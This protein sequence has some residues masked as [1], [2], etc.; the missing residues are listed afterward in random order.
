MASPRWPASMLLASLI[1][2]YWTTSFAWSHSSTDHSALYRIK[3]GMRSGTKENTEKI[4]EIVKSFLSVLKDVVENK[5]LK[6]MMQNLSAFAS[7]APGI[8]TLISA[9]INMALGFT[10][11]NDPLLKELEQGFAEVNRKLDSLSIKM[12]DLSTD[13]E[14]NSF[15]SIYSQ[16]EACILNAWKKFSELEKK[17]GFKNFKS[18][19]KKHEEHKNYKCTETSVENLY[20]Y[21]TVKTISLSKNLNE[22]LKKKFKCNL[23]VILKYNF[24]L[25]SLLL[26]GVV[27]RQVYWT[28]KDDKTSGKEAEL[29]EMFKNVYKHQQEVVEHCLN[30]Y[31]KYMKDDVEGI[32]LKYSP[33]KKEEIA[34]DVKDLLDKKYS[35][36]NW[37]VLV[38]DQEQEKATKLK[39]QKIYMYN[40]DKL[41]IGNIVVAVTYTLKSD[42]DK[43]KKIDD[44]RE[45]AEKCF[46]KNPRCHYECSLHPGDW[47]SGGEAMLL[48]NFAK[49]TLA[50]TNK[51]KF[52][53][54]PPPLNRMDC[55][56]GLYKY[57]VS[58]HVSRKLPVTDKVCKN[59]G[60]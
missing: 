14:W 8:G 5:N 60:H 33:D 57:K 22:L 28:L 44:V 2:L 49:V 54:F 46:Q 48:T 55:K 20:R 25:K 52:V 56:M 36:Y 42:S 9:I 29:V 18:V 32:A 6:D 41:I 31:K 27:L 17:A 10:P 47:S 53:E 12:S 11:E 51:A 19:A 21:L 15:A 38:Y 1:L 35:W 3:R 59:K 4:L 24:Y 30:N 37:V 34:K 43:E 23:N 45:F 26:K 16:D 50:A 7:L 39:N 58:V 40:M 13:V